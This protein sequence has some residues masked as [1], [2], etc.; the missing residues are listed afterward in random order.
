MDAAPVIAQL[1]LPNHPDGQDD[2]LGDT[3]KALECFENV[4]AGCRR[5]AGKRRGGYRCAA[6]SP[7]AVK[8]PTAP[9]KLVAS[10]RS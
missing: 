10:V 2:V 3:V 1:R 4:H 8:A 6:G 9:P 7:N 5:S